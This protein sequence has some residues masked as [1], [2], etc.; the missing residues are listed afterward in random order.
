[1]KTFKKDKLTVQQYPSRQEMGKAAAETVAAK[2]NE[3]LQQKEYINVIFASAP[4]QN[5]FLEHLRQLP[6]P[7]DRINA[8]HMDEY[9]GLHPDAPQGFGDLSGFD[10]KLTFAGDVLVGAASAAGEVWTGRGCA[11]G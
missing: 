8:F 11:R 6:V 4:S 2:M 7:F 10:F 9:V 5:E 1:M 3:L